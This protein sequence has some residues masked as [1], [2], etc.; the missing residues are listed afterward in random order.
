MEVKTRVHRCSMR[1]RHPV[2]E[3][4]YGV[5]HRR[6]KRRCTGPVYVKSS[7]QK[8]VTKSKTEAELVAL[9]DTAIQGIHQCNFVIAQGYD[10]G[11][12]ICLEGRRVDRAQTA[13]ATSTSVTSGTRSVWTGRRWLSSTLGRKRCFLMPLLSRHNV[14]SSFASVLD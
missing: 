14:L 3:V 11:P 8:I 6:R 2:R 7:K 1:C 12:V 4:A 5:R 13:R 10:L 9:S